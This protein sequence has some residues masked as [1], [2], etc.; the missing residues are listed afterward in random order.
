MFRVPLEVAKDEPIGILKIV[1][2]F[3]ADIRQNRRAS[4]GGQRIVNLGIA[5]RPAGGR[6]YFAFAAFCCRNE[7][8]YFLSVS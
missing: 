8:Q 1:R 6:H 5:G 4:Q 2:Q 7:D 3:L